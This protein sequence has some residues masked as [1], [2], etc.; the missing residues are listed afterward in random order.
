MAEDLRQHGAVERV[1]RGRDD[2][3]PHRVLVE[4]GAADAAPGRAQQHLARPGTGRA[5]GTS[6]TR[7]SWSPWNTAA[8]IGRLL[9]LGW[10]SGR[11]RCGGSAG[12]NSTLPSSSP[13]ARRSSWRRGRRAAAPSRRAR[14]RGR[15]SRGCSSAG[16]RSCGDT[17]AR[18][19]VRSVI[20]RI[21]SAW[22][23]TSCGP[24]GSPTWR[25]G[26]AGAHHRD[27]GGE[28]AGRAAG[29][30]DDVGAARRRRQPRRRSRRSRAPGRSRVAPE[31]QRRGPAGRR[32]S[33]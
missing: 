33:R 15:W 3:R 19:V 11:V 26:A 32:G 23:S 29:L 30:D 22:T 25:I 8:F 16:A 13:P 1:R 28:L 18:S 31:P 7:M 5:P 6:S 27:R 20:S 4:V 2:D 24:A 10:G 12:S 9:C 14:G 17:R 21:T